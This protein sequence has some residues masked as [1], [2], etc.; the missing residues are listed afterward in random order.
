[1]LTTYRYRSTHLPNASSSSWQS[2]RSN[3]V[4]I[5]EQYVNLDFTLWFLD[6]ISSESPFCPPHHRASWS[7]HEVPFEWNCSPSAEP[8]SPSTAANGHFVRNHFVSHSR[9]LGSF[10]HFSG[11]TRPS[12]YCSC[13]CQIWQTEVQRVKSNWRHFNFVTDVG[14]Q[15]SALYGKQN[16]WLL[17]TPTEKYS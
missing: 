7:G 8:S 10:K 2:E 15:K 9:T 14:G 1:M 5:Y 12:R 4:T 3:V 6:I 16:T 17:S 11:H 13:S